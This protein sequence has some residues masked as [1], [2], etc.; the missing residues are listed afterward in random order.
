MRDDCLQLTRQVA[1]VIVECGCCVSAHHKKWRAWNL[2]P[3]SPGSK[4]A[5]GGKTHK[6][7]GWAESECVVCCW[8]CFCV[9][10][11]SNPACPAYKL[12]LTC[13]QHQHF[14]CSHAHYWMWH[15]HTHHGVSTAAIED[16][17][18]KHMCR[19]GT[20]VCYRCHPSG[21]VCSK[22]AIFHCIFF[23]VLCHSTCHHGDELCLMLECI[24]CSIQQQRRAPLTLSHLTC[25]QKHAFKPAE[26]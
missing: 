1:Y 3:L 18:P 4:Q 8:S 11:P 15:K 19:C 6:K 9:L 26:Q 22:L 14:C 5:A 24:H 10:P 20:T 12:S 17:N 16:I 25:N 21:G 2:T 7:H 23:H 13:T